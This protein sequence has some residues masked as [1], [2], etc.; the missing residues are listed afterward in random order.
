MVPEH[1]DG[2]HLCFSRLG[3]SSCILI[4]Q[5]ASL[6]ETG[7]LLR[8][9]GHAVE[10]HDTATTAHY[11]QEANESTKGALLFTFELSLL[12]AVTVF[13]GSW[14]S[15]LWDW[16]WSRAMA[17]LR[18][19]LRG[20]ALHRAGV[21]HEGG[22]I[23]QFLVADCIPERTESILERGK[24]SSS[25]EIEVND[26]G[27]LRQCQHLAGHCIPLRSEEAGNVVF[28]LIH[29][30]GMDAIVGIEHI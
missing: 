19:L 26:D 20:E 11:N 6:F 3:I 28:E 24:P 25:F 10:G 29:E 13:V 21:H 12:H 17:H 23:H 15:L 5:P 18:A 14:L 2:T 22:Q 1:L 4:R 7:S 30:G 27:A 8:V 16:N 9:L